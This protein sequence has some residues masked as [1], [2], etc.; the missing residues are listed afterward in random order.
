MHP[1]L[2]RNRWN[3]P[4]QVS[5]SC[6]GLIGWWNSTVCLYSLTCDLSGD[7]N[8]CC[9]TILWV[10]HQI[11]RRVRGDLHY[12]YSKKQPKPTH[13]RLRKSMIQYIT[14]DLQCTAHHYINLKWTLM[15][16]VYRSNTDIK[17]KM[18]F[19]Q[20]KPTRKHYEIF[21]SAKEL[22]MMYIRFLH[23]YTGSRIQLLVVLV[24]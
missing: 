21:E 14:H 9:V 5:V 6:D 8:R 17:N 2:Q 12:I 18:S 16:F 23:I 4:V 19:H 7:V 15:S 24:L 11:R 22:C 20:L 1:L 10:W 13:K 3:W